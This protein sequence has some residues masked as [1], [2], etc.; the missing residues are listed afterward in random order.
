MSAPECV[1][2]AQMLEALEVV[3]AICERDDAAKH[4]SETI[5]AGNHGHFDG[6]KY[7]EAIEREA[8]TAARA[9]ALME[10]YRARW[11]R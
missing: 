5:S 9:S 10:A 8:R 4:R 7:H 11:S 3:T 6:A 2:R 1:N